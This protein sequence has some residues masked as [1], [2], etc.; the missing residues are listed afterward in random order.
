M[1][2]YNGVEYAIQRHVISREIVLM[3]HSRSH[4]I[5]QWSRECCDVS[6]DVKVTR[7]RTDEM[8]E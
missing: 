8:K 3:Q 6:A 4:A 2:F 5:D 7:I 1:I